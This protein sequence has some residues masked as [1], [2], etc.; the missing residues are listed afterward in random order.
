MLK[1]L[2]DISKNLTIGSLLDIIQVQMSRSPSRMRQFDYIYREVIVM[3]KTLAIILSV[4]MILSIV[5]IGASAATTYERPAAE[6]QKIT[7][8]AEFLAMEPNGY[9]SIENDLTLTKSYEQAFTGE[10]YGNGH[11]IQLSAPMFEDF[12]GGI[13]DLTLEGKITSDKKDVGAVARKAT[14]GDKI[15]F[16]NITVNVEIEV[17]DLEVIEFDESNNPKTIGGGKYAGGLLGYGDQYARLYFI[18]CKNTKDITNNVVMNSYSSES[19]ITKGINFSVYTGGIVGRCYRVFFSFC[20]NSGNISNKS[21]RGVAAGI[22]ANPGYGGKTFDVD[23]Y[24]CLNTGNITSGYDAGGMFGYL[25]SSNNKVDTYYIVR[26]ANYGTIKGGYRVGGMFGYCWAGTS[27]AYWTMEG[28]I[29]MADVYTG[30]PAY[31]DGSIGTAYVGLLTGYSNSAYNSYKNCV[32][33]GRV[34]A[35]ENAVV[36][37]PND[38]SLMLY[39]CVIGCSS[40]KTLTMPIENLY[41]CDYGT[42]EWYSYA[43]AEKNADQIIPIANRHEGVKLCTED[44]FGTVLTTL[45]TALNASALDDS[46]KDVMVLKDG[47]FE[48][49]ATKRAARLAKDTTDIIITTTT[50]E[51]EDTEP[52]DTEP[53]DTEPEATTT[54]KPNNTTKAP[55][56]DKPNTTT[57]NAGNDQ[58]C[59]GC[60]GFTTVAALAAVLV[61]G[62]AFVVVKKKF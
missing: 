56:T 39:K 37:D 1:L 7:S 43:T 52:E 10:I 4:A 30:L 47:V 34:L 24:D 40:A 60:G 17:T 44:E 57:G 28:C 59:A 36:N 53:E 51:V 22:A 2:W 25:G 11:K 15:T 33:K 48:F 3:R 8:E 26:C 62:A 12:N 41:L 20:E 23:A 54:D 31:A 14:E 16:L 49:D 61:G 21:N 58:G 38:G 27:S 5:V 50:E 19:N 29:S 35:N 6:L 32:A 55:T 42:T 46:E 18:N 13:C 9:Y 45:N